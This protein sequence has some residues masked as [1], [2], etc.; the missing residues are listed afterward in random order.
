MGGSVMKVFLESMCDGDPGCVVSKITGAEC[1]LAFICFAILAALFFPNLN[2]LASIAFVGSVTVLAYSS[3]LWILPVTKG[4]SGDG[5]A[6]EAMLV[7]GSPTR[8]RDALGGFEILALAFRGHNL[9]LEIQVKLYF[10][11][12]LKLETIPFWLVL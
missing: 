2:S 5:T 10:R 7:T 6:R 4:G 8:I 3:L 1:F 9:V 11:R 12:P